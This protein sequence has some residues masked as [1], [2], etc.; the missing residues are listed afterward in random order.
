MKIMVLR[1]LAIEVYKCLNGINP[2]YLNDL[3]TTK[4]HK[5]EL[6]YASKESVKAT[7]I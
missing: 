5:H 1:Y 6:R 4:E 3:F 2:K 7:S